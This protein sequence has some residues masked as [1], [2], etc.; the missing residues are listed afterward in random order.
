M[1]NSNINFHGEQ[2]GRQVRSAAHETFWE[3]C[4]SSGQINQVS[5]VQIKNV[6]SRQIEVHCTFIDNHCGC[7]SVTDMLFQLYQ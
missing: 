4:D 7:L 6:Y 1:N 5:A 3:Q 2:A